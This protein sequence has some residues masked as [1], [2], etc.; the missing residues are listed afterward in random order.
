MYFKLYFVGREAEDEERSY[1]FATFSFI[2]SP[3]KGHNPHLAKPDTHYGFVNAS[4]IKHLKR[5]DISIFL[6]VFRLVLE[7]YFETVFAELLENVG[8]F[9]TD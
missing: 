1:F 2:T 3:S 9:N 4:S 8:L 6:M 5:P 7:K